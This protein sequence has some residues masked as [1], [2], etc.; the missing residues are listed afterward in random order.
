MTH[1]IPA[2]A[3]MTQGLLRCPRFKARG[4]ARNNKAQAS[5]R[6]PKQ[7]TPLL[8]PLTG[9]VERLLLPNN[10]DRNDTPP[11][12]PPTGVVGKIYKNPVAKYRDRAIL[13]GP[14]H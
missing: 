1:W 9:V 2:C 10:R 8:L 3:G 5:L 12:S 7:R 11:L 13:K 6:T 4:K 14:D